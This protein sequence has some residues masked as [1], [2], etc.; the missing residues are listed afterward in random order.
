MTGTGKW[1]GKQE[2]LGP[3][4]QG[5]KENSLRSDG[6]LGD[7]QMLCK[8]TGTMNQCEGEKGRWATYL[9]RRQGAGG[10]L[11]LAWQRNWEKSQRRGRLGEGTWMDGNDKKPEGEIGTDWARR[12]ALGVGRK[13]QS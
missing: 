12:W 6:E 3:S 8:E 2:G 11:G 1:P 4:W 9:R 10:E 13:R 7:E 5:W